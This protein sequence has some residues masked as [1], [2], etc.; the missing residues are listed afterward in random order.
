MGNSKQVHS[1]RDQWIR[2]FVLK[3][4]Y[5]LFRWAAALVIARRSFAFSF[6]LG[7]SLGSA[8]FCALRFP[9]FALV[10]DLGA[11]AESG[12]APNNS[13]PIDGL[14]GSAAE[15]LLE[16]GPRGARLVGRLE[17]DDSAS[18]ALLILSFRRLR[19]SGHRG[20]AAGEGTR[21]SRLV[22]IFPIPVN[23]VTHMNP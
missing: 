20:L 9:P 17:F 13:S 4:N 7:A 16:T 21:R 23:C 14:P 3:I 5:K 6:A 12:N 15:L 11:A 1:S 2:R 19:L 8:F 10:F 22:A 18:F